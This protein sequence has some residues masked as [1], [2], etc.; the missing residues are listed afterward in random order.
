MT[1]KIKKEKLLYLLV[2]QNLKSSGYYTIISFP[3]QATGYNNPAIVEELLK[4]RANPNIRNIRNET[5]LLRGYYFESKYRHR[6]TYL[7]FQSIYFIYISAANFN[8]IEIAKLLIENEATDLNI[9]DSNDQTPLMKGILYM[10]LS[11]MK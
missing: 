5:A 2:F 4:A 10:P 1:S 8:F 9:K 6:L 3:I 7:I 11:L